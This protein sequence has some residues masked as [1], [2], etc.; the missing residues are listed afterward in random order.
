MVIF[1]PKCGTQ[2]VDDQSSFCNKCGTQLPVKTAEEPDNYCPNCNTK[3]QGSETVCSRCGFLL[4]PKQLSIQPAK[5]GKTCPEC[6]APIIDENRYYCKSCG[7]YIRDTQGRKASV[8]DDSSSGSKASG[9]KPVIIP[10]IHQNTGTGTIIKPEPVV[11]KRTIDLANPM[12]KKT[13]IIVFVLVGIVILIWSA[14]T[15]LQSGAILQSDSDVLITQDL[16]SMALKLDDLP[17]G[18]MS[19]DAEGTTDAYSAQFFSVSGFSEGLVEQ[20]ITQFPG[21]EEAKLE[22]NSERAQATGVTLETLN[23]GNEGFGYIDVNYVM[24]IF[25]RGNIIVKIEDTRTE[26]QEN[27]TMNNAKN[28]AEITAKRIN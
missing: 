27:P 4:S 2:A 20:T 23:I 7:A 11:I 5:P 12:L 24:V 16:D 3:I 6:G 22:L 15:L 21:I 18:W 8:M 10:G 19:G 13:G 26:Y 25:R 1:C 17:S 28:Y 9:K 14:V